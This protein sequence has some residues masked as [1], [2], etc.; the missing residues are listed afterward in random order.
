ML[1]A[2]KRG[3]VSAGKT[4]KSLPVILDLL[5]FAS[6]PNPFSRLRNSKA[7][8][9]KSGPSPKAHA[10]QRPIHKAAG[11]TKVGLKPK[12]DWHKRNFLTEVL[13]PSLFAKRLGKHEVPGLPV[14]QRRRT[15]RHVD[16][17]RLI[18]A[19]IGESKPAN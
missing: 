18:S 15:R 3:K 8:I 14:A 4:T 10:M 9:K 6:V 17:A 16:R 7:E 2:L 11:A 5:N 12:G 1:P 19:P 13:I